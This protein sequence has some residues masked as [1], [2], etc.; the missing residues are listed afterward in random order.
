MH[1]AARDATAPDL[2]RL[3]AL[4][5]GLAEEQA[6]LRPLWH[7]SEGVGP[8]VAERLAGLI[9]Q[10]AVTV[11]TIDDAVFGFLLHEIRDLADGTPVGV[12]R[13]VYTEPEARGV[14][15]GDAMFHHAV[16]GLRDQGITRFDAVVSPGHREAKNFYEAHGF[17]ARR[18]TMH[19]DD[20]PVA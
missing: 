2:P 3:E 14:G 18:I 16:G 11:G 12:I 9:A 4:Y 20:P 5:A 17:S 1:I 19:A 7:E 10:G 15:L 8:N 6:A 13:Y